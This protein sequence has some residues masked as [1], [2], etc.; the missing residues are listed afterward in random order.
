MRCLYHVT[1]RPI[2]PRRDRH[3]GGVGIAVG[4][5]LVI[6]RMRLMGVT[7]RIQDSPLH[8]VDGSAMVF[9]RAVRHSWGRWSWAPTPRTYILSRSGAGRKVQ[10]LWKNHRRAASFPRILSP[11]RPGAGIHVRPRKAT[12]RRGHVVT[13]G[14]DSSRPFRRQ[15]ILSFLAAEKAAIAVLPKTPPVSLR[16]TA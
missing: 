6:A 15:Q 2:L 5:I 3:E 16:R 14:R 12:L 7:R 1:K 11:R 10:C 4:A 8:E 13:Q 9:V